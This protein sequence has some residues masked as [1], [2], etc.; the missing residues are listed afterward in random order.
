[1]SEAEATVQL[2]LSRIIAPRDILVLSSQQDCISLT[3]SAPYGTSERSVRSCFVKPAR[4]HFART[5]RA[6]RDATYMC[7]L[8]WRCGPC[9]AAASR[10]GLPLCGS[11]PD[12]VC[13]AYVAF[14]SALV[15]RCNTA[16][17]SRFTARYTLYTSSCTLISDD[18]CRCYRQ[19]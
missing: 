7:E 12:S 4:L 17:V 8:A 6:L 3:L 14:L 18:Y 10:A 11:G 16:S 15:Y 19:I 13:V 1:M 9:G 5:A 2:I